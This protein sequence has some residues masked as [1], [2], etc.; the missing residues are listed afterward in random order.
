MHGADLPCLDVAIRS[1]V[2]CSV[3]A[4]A[5]QRHRDDLARQASLVPRS[6]V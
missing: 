6:S 4:L 5:P 2:F 3:L 1:Q